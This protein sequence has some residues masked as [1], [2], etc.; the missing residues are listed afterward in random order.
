MINTFFNLS[1][2]GGIDEQIQRV[3]LQEWIWHDLETSW[4]ALARGRKATSYASGI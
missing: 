1:Q 2:Y 3:P 4:Y